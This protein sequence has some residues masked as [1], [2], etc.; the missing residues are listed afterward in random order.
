ML[1]PSCG[2]ETPQQATCANCGATLSPAAR[3]PIALFKWGSLL[4]AIA[5]VVALIISAS[6]LAV[7]QV[8]I[9]ELNATTNLAYVQVSGTVSSTPRFDS[10][11][12]FLS[13]H[14]DD[15]TGDLTVNAYRSET[16]FLISNSLTPQLGDRITLEGTLR[17]REDS[18]SLTLAAPERV[19]LEHPQPTER[20]IGSLTVDD[21]LTLVLIRGQI[22]DKREP[23]PGFNVW[24]IADPTG[25]IDATIPLDVVS[26]TGPLPDL[27]SGDSVQLSGLITLYRNQPQLTLTSTQTILKLA[28]GSIVFPT[29]APTPSPLPPT[30]VTIN[31]LSLAFIGSTVM[32]EG[33]IQEADDFSQGKHFTFKDDT[34]QITLLLWQDLIDELTL[35]DQLQVGIK[36]RVI[37]QIEEFNGEMEIIP[38]TSSDL[39]II[40]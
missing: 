2:R 25:Q 10:A 34:G 32:L 38:A 27:A 14:L 35:A 21:E 29:P 23:F 22:V 13:F 5:G 3:L 24:V 15:G 16:Q 30:L 6:R 1:C 37:G 18:I 7:P 8:T 20:L 39:T 26:L 33:T 31:Q 17:L 40:P 9:G 4:L 28:P 19:V 36:L 12:N 11:T